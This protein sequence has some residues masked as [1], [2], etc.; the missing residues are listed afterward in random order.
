MTAAE[1]IMEN[2]SLFDVAGYPTYVFLAIFFVI[3]TLALRFGDHMPSPWPVSVAGMCILTPIAWL[4]VSGVDYMMLEDDLGDIRELEQSIEELDG[5]VPHP[6]L[7]A[8][9][10]N[11]ENLVQAV[12]DTGGFGDYGRVFENAENLTDGRVYAQSEHARFVVD[13]MVAS[14]FKFETVPDEIRTVISVYPFS[15]RQLEKS[16]DRVAY[17]VG[18]S[19]PMCNGYNI[20]K[21]IRA[22]Y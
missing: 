12:K 20:I 22:V 10:S 11:K 3:G 19:N 15:I 2:V 9:E 4:V 6:Y 18:V 13:S 17:K 8:F 1:F 5:M 16:W 21:N 7:V 14:C